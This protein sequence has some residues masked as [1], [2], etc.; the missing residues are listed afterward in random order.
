MRAAPRCSP[1]EGTSAAIRPPPTATL[2]AAACSLIFTEGL[3]EAM[4]RFSARY[5]PV[6]RFANPSALNGAA[7][8][9]FLNSPGDIAHV[10]AANPKNYAERCETGEPGLCSL[11]RRWRRMQLCTAT[12]RAPGCLPCSPCLASGALDPLCGHHFIS[13]PMLPPLFI[14]TMQ[15]C[16]TSTS[17]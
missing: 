10:C 8:W 3:H 9:V 13:Q 4:L 17:A 1:S 12:G 16:P 5:G 14:N 6:S 7:G 15:S 11:G 2:P